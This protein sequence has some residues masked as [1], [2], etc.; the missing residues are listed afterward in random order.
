MITIAVIYATNFLGDG[1]A[2]TCSSSCPHAYGITHACIHAPYLP[3]VTYRVSDH[4]YV[5]IFIQ[6]EWLADRMHGKGKYTYSTGKVSAYSQALF[7]CLHE[8]MHGSSHA[9]VP[10][11]K[12]SLTC[13]ING[14]VYDGMWAEDRPHGDGKLLDGGNVYDMT[15]LHGAL[16][17]FFCLC[18]KLCDMPL[19]LQHRGSCGPFTP[20]CLGV[21][22][23][24]SAHARLNYQRRVI[25]WS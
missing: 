2:C 17:H 12:C 22:I 9:R 7:H 6:G 24:V 10:K 19:R 1:P 21:I 25:I 18:V 8:G 11:H 16:H 3:V 4:H 14:Q 5:A 13:T 23:D 15:Y 20:M